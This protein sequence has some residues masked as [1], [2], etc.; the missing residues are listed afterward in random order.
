MARH[1]MVNGVKVMFTPEEETVRN[2]EEQ[3]WTDGAL[4]R[5]ASTEIQRLEATI[6]P[7]RLRDALA[8]DTGKK[9]VADVEALIATERSKL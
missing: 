8:N 3:A 7:R 5:N 2:I 9:W 6:T 4:S 1:K